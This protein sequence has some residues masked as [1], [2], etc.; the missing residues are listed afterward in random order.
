MSNQAENSNIK[1]VTQPEL[2]LQ[3]ATAR[4]MAQRAEA[5]AQLMVFLNSASAVADH[6]GIVNEILNQ[7][8]SLAEAE[9]CLETLK[10]NLSTTP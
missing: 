5:I 2:L 6:P 4:L 1:N 9:G 8:H 10:K 3:A 7:I